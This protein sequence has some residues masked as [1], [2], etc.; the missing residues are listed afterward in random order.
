MTETFS[1]VMVTAHRRLPKGCVDEWLRAALINAV[2]KL[3]DE[4]GLERATTGMAI[5][6]D[7]VFGRVIKNMGLPLRAAIPYP[8][9]P[10]DGTD[11][12]FGSIW[13]K[14]QRAEWDELE[15]YADLTGGVHRVS[16]VNPRSFDERVTM[17][18]RR[19]DWMLENT[20]AV[21]GIWAPNSN[22]RS[23]TRSCLRKAVSAGKPIV[24]VN[25]VRKTVTR[26]LPHHMERHFAGHRARLAE[27]A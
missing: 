26:P 15:M 18:H 2:A 19:N 23:G 16:K 4:Y 9:Q 5:G 10:L 24:L 7:L 17:L 6:G 12:H 8:D 22:P 3:R 20:Q 13:T 14:A 21:I 27:E 1:E 25:L 11:G